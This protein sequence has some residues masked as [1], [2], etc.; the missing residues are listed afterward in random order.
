MLL[1]AI[2]LLLLC[3]P[4]WH[5]MVHGQLNLLLLLLLTGVWLA[6]RQGHPYWAGG[7]LG[8][9]TAIKLYPGFLFIYFLL[10]RD[11]PVLRAGLIALVALTGLTALVLGPEA[12]CSYFVEVLPRTSLRRADWHNLSLAGVWCKLFDVPLHLPPVQIVPLIESPTL[13]MVGMV[14]TLLAIAAVLAL[15]LPRLWAAK[16]TDLAYGLTLIAM[17]LVSPI[18]W[19][20]YLLVLALPLVI[21]WQRLQGRWL[22]RLILLALLTVLWLEP[23]LV[24]IDGLRW[25]EWLGLTDGRPW[26]SATPAATLTALSIPCYALLG[27]FIL[28][29]VTGVRPRPVN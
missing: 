9:A 26:W 16:D 2:T 13:T 24:M 12:Y 27:L 28:A 3:H 8:L 22:A 15:V 1:P 21:L 4:F 5:Q 17:L 19:D 6:D 25:L 7:L 29:L 11:W 23:G 20:H 14:G 10:K 18:T